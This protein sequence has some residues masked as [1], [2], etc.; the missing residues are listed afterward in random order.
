MYFDVFLSPVLLVLVVFLQ[1]LK[2]NISLIHFIKKNLFY[3][4]WNKHPHLIDRDSF[5]LLQ[6]YVNQ[7]ELLIVHVDF[8]QHLMI[9]NRN[10]YPH[11]PQRQQVMS[12]KKSNFTN[13]DWVWILLCKEEYHSRESSHWYSIP[14]L[15]MLIVLWKNQIGYLRRKYDFDI[16]QR[17]SR[18]NWNFSWTLSFNA[19]IERRDSANFCASLNHTIWLKRIKQFSYIWEII[20]RKY[21]AF[22]SSWIDLSGSSGAEINELI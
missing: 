18:I 5:V 9:W 17:Y 6:S 3:H 10:M 13:E 11:V 2:K 14:L 12:S 19:G 16:L 7:R 21:S 4:L 1:I 8:H 15:K 20:S 22:R